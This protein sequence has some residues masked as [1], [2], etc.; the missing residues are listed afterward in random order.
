[1]CDLLVTNVIQ[2]QFQALQ[3]LAD[4][5]CGNQLMTHYRLPVGIPSPF[6]MYGDVPLTVCELSAIFC[7]QKE[8]VLADR[9]R[10]WQ[11]IT[12]LLQR[13][14]IVFYSRVI[15]VKLYLGPSLEL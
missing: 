4:E 13:L 7:C 1:M 6:V 14:T 5:I 10:R 9:K 2:K 15:Q 11:D 12:S 8:G 3:Q